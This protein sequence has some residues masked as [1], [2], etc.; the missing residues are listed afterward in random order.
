M[1]RDE[2][3]MLWAKVT[4]KIGSEINDLIDGAPEALDTLK[5]IADKL[6]DDDDAIAA[7]VN[8]I[9][10]KADLPLIV[11]APDQYSYQKMTR[12]DAKALVEA[13]NSGRECYYQEISNGSQPLYKLIRVHNNYPWVMLYFLN[14]TY[15]TYTNVFDVS[16]LWFS[17]DRTSEDPDTTKLT[18]LFTKASDNFYTKEDTNAL[19][20][21]KANKTLV[22]TVTT[23]IG[24]VFQKDK[25]YAELLAAYNAGQ[26]VSAVFEG[27]IVPLVTVGNNTLTFITT[28]NDKT[29][30]IA[31]N[32]SDQVTVTV[33]GLQ[34]EL[35]FDSSPTAS[36]TNPVTS[37]GVKTAMDGK[38]DKNKA[39]APLEFSGLG[40]K[41]LEKNIVDVSGTDKNVL[42]QVM[43]Q[44]GQG[45]ALTNYVFVVQYDYDLNA[46]SVTIPT[47]STLKFEGGSISNG[48]I[49]GN[50]CVIEGQADIRCSI[51]GIKNDVTHL[52]W[53]TKDSNKNSA[54]ARALA[55]A[56]STILDG[57][58]EAITLTQTVTFGAGNS[59]DLRNLVINFTASSNGQNM[60]LF[61]SSTQWQGITNNISHCTFTL[62]NPSSYQN[63]HCLHLRRWYN[64]SR[65]EISDVFVKD[66]SG[67]MYVCESYLQEANF[68]RFKGANV[69]GF[70]SFNREYNTANAFGTFG[71]GSSNII[72]FTQC[73]IDGGLNTN[74]T[75]TDVVSVTKLIL[76]SFDS[77]VFQGT[78]NSVAQNTYYFT[79]YNTGFICNVKATNTWSE[80]VSFGNSCHIEDDI[81]VESNAHFAEKYIFVG[82]HN[83]LV[84]ELTPMTEQYAASGNYFDIQ[85]GAYPTIRLTPNGSYYYVNSIIETC[86]N[87][88]NLIIDGAN[89]G[90]PSAPTSAVYYR[91]GTSID[92]LN[93]I[94]K[95]STSYCRRYFIYENGIRILHQYAYDGTGPLYFMANEAARRIFL[96]NGRRAYFHLIYRVYPLVEVTS[97]N[98]S[99]FN[100]AGIT[101]NNGVLQGG[102]FN[103]F[104]AGQ[105][106]TPSDNIW[107][108]VL[109]QVAPN[110]T[111]P[112]KFSGGKWA[113]DIAVCEIVDGAHPLKQNIMI[114]PSDATK[115]INLTSYTNDYGA[116]DYAPSLDSTMYG[117]EYFDTTI[118]MPTFWDGSR[119]V[120]GQGCKAAPHKGTTANRP[121][122]A[123]GDA[124]FT[125]WDTTLGKM[126]AWSGSA[127]VNLDGTALS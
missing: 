10:T 107:R 33:V 121:T 23:A 31:I 2:L 21:A 126:I 32:S 46:Q 6:G 36:S 60:F 5:E 117:Y 42:T 66:F 75:I 89:S 104:V 13:Y 127:W 4:G 29:C 123:S 45:N 94:R 118:K 3:T 111:N 78:K 47:N 98:L 82:K 115:L 55:C 87:K 101:N 125:Y 105:S 56:G 76:C 116:T 50:G 18:G 61:D 22:V 92:L 85:S 112:A 26:N 73:G 17:Y 25:T 81:C 119:W 24:G 88:C 69:G 62:T 58:N 109:T 124:G 8:E 59:C 63:V 30:T 48:T 114:D 86:A 35:T 96:S 15:G 39:Y 99:Q 79:R 38:V 43:L 110:I 64:T 51:S 67:Y 37:G 27:A 57:D 28:I 100:S 103:P 71:T 108:Q 122:L 14:K 95:I 106:L 41:T 16:F 72:T 53:F 83:A 91:E 7:L 84:T 70:I 80:F 120:D 54:F 74:T 40:K 65:S 97:E 9:A 11:T 90:V 1:T 49:V 52:K 102:N 77:C 44:D 68:I 34:T 20:A 19:L 113:M 12:G 93:D